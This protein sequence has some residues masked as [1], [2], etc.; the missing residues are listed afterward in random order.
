MSRR[1]PRT[2]KYRMWVGYLKY[3]VFLQQG[4]SVRVLMGVFIFLLSIYLINYELSAK[5]S[6]G[7]ESS[8]LSAVVIL[9]IIKFIWETYVTQKEI[10]SYFHIQRSILRNNLS[11]PIV[12]PGVKEIEEGF[13]P[14]EI[15]GNK[16]D[17]VF[18]SQAINRLIQTAPLSINLSRA[19]KKHINSYIQ[20]HR[21]I[22]LQYL[23]HYFF[24]SLYSNLQFTNDKKLCLSKD[25]Q[26]NSNHVIC[27][28]GGYY[29]S[30]LTNQVSGTTLKI[31]DRKHTTITTE[32]IFPALTDESGKRYLSDIAS[33]QMNDHLGC[34]TI[35][36][37]RDNYILIWI[38]A[39]T[40]Q[41]SRDLLTPT[42]S[43][44]SNISDMVSHNLQKTLI[45]TM[46]R[47][48]TEESSPDESLDN[49]LNR[50]LI[51]GF[52]RW[53]TRGGKPEFSGIT[54]LPGTA[55]QYK[56]DPKEART[57]RSSSLKFKV[58]S[59][60]ELPKVLK[61]IRSHNHLSTPLYMCLYQLEEMY[62]N[63]KEE[64]VKFM[65]NK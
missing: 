49:S 16:S 45:H 41:F 61:E 24:T 60:D 54:K 25:I 30:F 50:T 40:T 26:L 43:G 29:D 38:Q 13:V 23:N 64:L 34:S 12:Q 28:A 31:L 22:L 44:S 48:L 2:I 51:L 42:G 27:H 1:L 17:L 19:K 56:P 18:A 9:I 57:E 3:L 55:H 35:G 47:E 11:K 21:E 32:H 37:T 46:E 52:Y 20:T 10:R 7:H 62:K 14:I 58:S 59:I 65:F 53:V 4:E 8:A 6:D 5:F 39:S 15:P 33:S 36:F 63:Q